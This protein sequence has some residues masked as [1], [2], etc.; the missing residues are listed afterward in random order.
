MATAGSRAGQLPLAGDASQEGESA[1]S[2]DDDEPPTATTGSAPAKR[3]G[4]RKP[5]PRNLPRTQTVIEPSEAARTCARCT[6]AKTC[7]GSD[8][9]EELD[10]TPAVLQVNEI[11]RPKYACP[12]CE[13]GVVQAPVPARA[14]DQGRPGPGLLAHVVTSKYADHLPLHRLEGIFGRGGLRVSRRTLC[15]WVAAVAELVEPIVKVLHA[16]VKTSP[17]VYSDD[18]PITVQDRQHPGGSRRAYIWV[19]GGDQGDV[20]YDYTPGRSREGPARMLEGYAGTCKQTPTRDTTRSS[21][22]DRSSKSPVGRMRGGTSR[23]R[24]RRRS[25]RRRPCSR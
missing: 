8:V 11:V 1:T 17:V 16:T 22:T 25:S 19:Y 6:T 15:D 10:Y 12:H 21:P 7:I 5:I 2:D 13:D 24:S 3:R 18:T 9:T 23:R 20:V 4:G 14:I